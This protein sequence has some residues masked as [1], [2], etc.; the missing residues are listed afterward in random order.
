LHDGRAST[1]SEAIL[2]H[3]GQA[4]AS[5]QAFVELLSSEQAEL[6]S[7]LSAL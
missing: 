5:R 2:A 4:T 7:F 6:L 3:A 1:V